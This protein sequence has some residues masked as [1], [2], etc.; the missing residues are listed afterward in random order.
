[1]Y[2]QVILQV[3]YC[4][5]KPHSE[6]TVTGKCIHKYSYISVNIAILSKAGEYYKGECIHTG[7]K[8]PGVPMV[9]G[10]TYILSNGVGMIT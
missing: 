8:A 5:T 3:I 9:T 10:G 6:N 2:T 4:D 1:M 7:F